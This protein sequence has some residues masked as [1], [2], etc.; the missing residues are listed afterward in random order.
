MDVI[1]IMAYEGGY[2]EK[3][4]R[5]IGDLISAGGGRTGTGGR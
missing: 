2:Y 3:D 1:F 5:H 4:T